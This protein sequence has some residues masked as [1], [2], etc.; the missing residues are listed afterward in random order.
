MHPGGRGDDESKVQVE[1]RKVVYHPKAFEELIEA[2]DYYEACSHG[3]GERFLDNVENAVNFIRHSGLVF[4]PDKSGRRKYIVKKFP[5]LL[6][7]RVK[8]DHIFI[9]AVA[10]AARKPDYWK[11]RDNGK[12]KEKP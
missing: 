6:I 9:L 11:S 12:M 7:Y 4:S 10:H 2:A 5:Y 8:E 3:L 1:Q